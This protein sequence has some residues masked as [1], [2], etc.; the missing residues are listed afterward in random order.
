MVQQDNP[1]VRHLP[2]RY[3][4]VSLRV[5]YTQFA[6]HH[7]KPATNQMKASLPKRVTS[8][9]QANHNSLLLT[10]RFTPWDGTE[11]GEW[12]SPQYAACIVEAATRTAAASS[13][14]M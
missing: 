14:G 1:P 4:L 2:I 9:G 3:L 11:M 5:A 8:R 7:P 13:D 12:Q 10:M 6:T